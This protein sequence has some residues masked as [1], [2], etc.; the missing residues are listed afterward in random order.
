MLRFAFRR[1][2]QGLIVLWLITILVFGIFFVAPNDV[3]RTLA[4]RQ[5]TP[6]TVELIS[7]RLGLDQ[8]IWRQYGHFIWRAVHGDLGFDYY[9]G[10]QVTSVIMADIPATLS[11]A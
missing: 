8:P 5:A 1:V 6:Q 11:L 3:A 7:E 2:G 4:G 9:H 10:R